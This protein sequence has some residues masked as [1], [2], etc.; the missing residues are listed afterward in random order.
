[1]RCQSSKYLLPIIFLPSLSLSHS[2][3]PIGAILCFQEYLREESSRFVVLD[4]QWLVEVMAS[5]VNVQTQ[6]ILKE[7][8]VSTG[9]LAHIWKKYSTEIQEQ[10]LRIL[11]GFG[12]VFML[13]GGTEER[14]RIFRDF[15]ML[16]LPSSS[17]ST[18][19]PSPPSL[20]PSSLSF[21][22]LSPPSTSLMP[23]PSLNSISRYI[24]PPK[25][26]LPKTIPSSPS[27][28]FF[29]DISD[30]P[31]AIDW[32]RSIPT[33]VTSSSSSSSSSSFSSS[34]FSNSPSLSPSSPSPLSH[35]LPSSSSS[36]S[37]SSS[38]QQLIGVRSIDSKE[39]EKRPVGT[40]QSTSGSILASQPSNEQQI[41][42]PCLLPSNSEYG[43]SMWSHAFEGI[44]F[45]RIYR[46]P[47]LPLGKG[48]LQPIH[49]PQSICLSK[50]L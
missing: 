7:G 38:R 1:M 33:P 6:H 5:L 12:M 30:S 43:R 11:E 28:E 46:F 24:L 40:N 45:Y 8:I 14:R 27:C 10:F 19:T 41:L 32:I 4:P 39:E 44:S 31:H 35:S 16:Q 25:K 2:H 18:P 3:A 42:I 29:F 15:S 23:S 22:P 21:S 47:F 17:S 13:S 20:P 49:F 36:F 26:T 37:S 34:F 48:L 9:Q 50:Y